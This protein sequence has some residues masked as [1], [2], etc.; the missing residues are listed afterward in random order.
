MSVLVKTNEY[1]Y[2]IIVDKDDMRQMVIDHCGYDMEDDV[3]EFDVF[4]LTEEQ[5]DFLDNE[6]EEYISY[7]LEP[8]DFHQNIFRES[9][10]EWKKPIYPTF[11]DTCVEHYMKEVK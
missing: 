9:L 6:I 8:Q 7:H 3:E 10:R 11:L 5:E 4:N 2:N 1:G